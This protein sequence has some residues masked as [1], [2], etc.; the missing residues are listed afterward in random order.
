MAVIALDYLALAGIAA[1]VLLAVRLWIGNP[2][3]MLE[4][5]ALLFAILGAM[6]A[7]ADVW[8]DPYGYS[9]ILSP[10]L[11]LL[12][13]RALD[14]RRALLALPVF[15]VT[16]RVAVQLVP[17]VLGILGFPVQP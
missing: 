12:A 17:Q 4:W 15:A 14:T 16:P 11:L 7:R 6:L 5:A 3:G 8:D 13:W 10:L 1:A 9:R 2:R